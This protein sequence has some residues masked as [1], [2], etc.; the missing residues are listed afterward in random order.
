VPKTGL[1]QVNQPHFSDPGARAWGE[2]S[3]LTEDD[4]FLRSLGASQLSRDSVYVRNIRK[5]GL[6]LTLIWDV[7]RSEIWARTDWRPKGWI[8][9]EARENGSGRVELFNEQRAATGVTNTLVALI[10]DMGSIPSPF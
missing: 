10:E 8:R 7:E 5:N 3:G 2:L 9:F 4:Q 6:T 1:C